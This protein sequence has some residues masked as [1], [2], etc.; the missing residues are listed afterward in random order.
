MA[1]SHFVQFQLQVS[2]PTANARYD[3]LV[4]MGLVDS[5]KPEIDSSR[6]YFHK[7]KQFLARKTLSK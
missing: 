3:R 5:L 1:E 2:M 6:I 4:D 7:R